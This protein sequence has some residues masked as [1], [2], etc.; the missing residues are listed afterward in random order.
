MRLEKTQ[1][2]IRHSPLYMQAEEIREAEKEKRAKMDEEMSSM[3]EAADEDDEETEESSGDDEAQV[4]V[5]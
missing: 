4:S 1:D 2:L 5:T 3:F